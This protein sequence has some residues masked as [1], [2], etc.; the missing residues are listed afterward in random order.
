MNDN[1]KELIWVSKEF[2]TKYESLLKG[3][4]KQEIINKELEE[5]MAKVK[6]DIREEF[7]TSLE[8]L[9][10]DAAMY[11]GLMLKTKETFTK[12]KDEALSSLYSIWEEYDK[13]RANILQ[14][15][16]FLKE[17]LTPLKNDIDEINN[18]LN[19]I[20]KYPLEKMLELLAKYNNS[21]EE[22]K[23]MMNFLFENYK[24]K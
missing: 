3:N 10:E 8:T 11:R 6:E 7:R 19:K 9:E 13:D 20:D 14:K 17:L 1:K 5:Y 21:P 23:N 15:L 22:S 2:A 4:E 12:V 16:Q 18:A 24:M